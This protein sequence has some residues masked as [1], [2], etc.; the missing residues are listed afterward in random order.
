MLQKFKITSCAFFLCLFGLTLKTGAGTIGQAQEIPGQ[1]GEQER[2]QGGSADDWCS[3]Y[4]SGPDH[5]ENRQQWMG[6]LLAT[7]P[8]FMGYP[9]TVDS[10]G[11]AGRYPYIEEVVDHAVMTACIASYEEGEKQSNTLN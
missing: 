11:T 5:I 8:K 4:V 9:V 1:V 6:D 10:F 7:K 2:W 3:K